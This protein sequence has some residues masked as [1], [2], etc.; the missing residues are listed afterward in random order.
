MDH[1]TEIGLLK[2]A[3]Q[4]ADK[5]T[6]EADKRTA[7]AHIQLG[8]ANKQ[9]DHTKWWTGFIMSGVAVIIAV[10]GLAFTLYSALKPT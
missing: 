2:F 6:L 3:A 10:V 4:E 5:R 1:A 8:F 9:T 7:A